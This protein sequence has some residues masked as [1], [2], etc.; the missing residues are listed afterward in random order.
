M[1]AEQIIQVPVQEDIVAAGGEGDGE[2]AA[3]LA[4]HRLGAD[5]KGE[6]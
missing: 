5:E 2:V 4:E 6:G 3:D 1:G